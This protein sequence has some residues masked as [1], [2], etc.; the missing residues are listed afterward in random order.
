MCF[1]KMCENFKI[2]NI[3]KHMEYYSKFYPE[4]MNEKIRFMFTKL[5]IFRFVYG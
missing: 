5:H 2:C 1:I 3:L 4:C